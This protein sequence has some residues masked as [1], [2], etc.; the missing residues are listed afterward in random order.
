[1]NRFAVGPLI[2]IFMM[3]FSL[4]AQAN[5]NELK[6]GTEI[7]LTSFDRKSGSFEILIVKENAVGPNYAY[8]KDLVNAMELSGGVSE[9]KKQYPQ[10]KAK[11]LTLK[12][13]LKLLTDQELTRYGLD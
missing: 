1:M 6:E 11:A 13:P 5:L 7:K 3:S 8:V 9:F 4:S 10:L 12:K 2:L